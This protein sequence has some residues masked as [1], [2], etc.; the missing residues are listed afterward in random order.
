MSPDQINSS[1]Y[2]EADVAQASTDDVL[3]YSE[4]VLQKYLKADNFEDKNM[5][6]GSGQVL[7]PKAHITLKRMESSQEGSLEDHLLET[8][9]G[10]FDH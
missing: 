10:N 3:K 5:L 6:S 8:E 7:P 4:Q 1:Q 9:Y 2:L